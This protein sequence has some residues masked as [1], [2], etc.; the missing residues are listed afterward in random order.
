MTLFPLPLGELFGHYGAYVVYLFIGVLFGATLETAGFG[1]SKKLAAQFYFK[2]LTVFKVMF[3][4][5]IVACTLIFLSSAMGLLDYNLLWVPP[6]YLWPGIVG[7]LIMGVGFIV[8]GFCPGT[9]LVAMATGKIDGVF[10]VLGVLTG[11]FL[12]GETVSSFAVF[13]DSSYMGRFTLPELFGVSYGVV[14][15]AVVL[16]ALLMFWGAEK[17]EG[18]VGGPTAQRAP[19]WAP[20]GAVGL[21]ALAFASLVIG[22]PDNADRWERIEAGQTALLDERAVQIEPA[23]LLSLI[24]D[25]RIKA[26][27]LDVRDERHYN[28]FHIQGAKRLPQ[29]EVAAAASELLREPAN[30]V[31]VTMSNDET[32]ATEAWKQLKAESLPNVYILAGGV[33]AWIRTFGD[34][35][36]LQENLV[37]GRENEQMAY[38]FEAA[39]GARHPAS[40]PNP[41]AFEIEFEPKVKLELKRAAEGGGCG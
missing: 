15:V 9:S 39:L 12:F 21:V 28:Q 1:N 29:G 8:G 36:F 22:Q 5:I 2:D 3:T 6:T 4:A 7:G 31:F 30:T 18:A 17:V 14:V 16:M 11:I 27:L 19:R 38:R 40:E 37:R 10:F 26:V 34:D 13:F 23:E 33:N 32:G 41:A 24:Y 25:S 20:A 35:A